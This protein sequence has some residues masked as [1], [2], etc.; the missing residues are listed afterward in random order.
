MDHLPERLRD[1]ILFMNEISAF[2]LLAVELE[3][4]RHGSIEVG[5]PK[6]FGTEARGAG[7]SE[8]ALGPKRGVARGRLSDAGV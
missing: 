5:Y 8:S 3:Y 2:R 1:L 4:Y 7:R 6:L